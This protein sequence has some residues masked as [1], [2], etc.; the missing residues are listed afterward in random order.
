MPFQSLLGLWPVSAME[1]FAQ[2]G[3]LSNTLMHLAKTTKFQEWWSKTFLTQDQISIQVCE[4]SITSISKISATIK[5]KIARDNEMMGWG[6]MIQ[7]AYHNFIWAW[8]SINFYLN[9]KRLIFSINKVLVY[10]RKYSKWKKLKGWDNLKVFAARQE[11]Q[12]DQI[13]VVH[14][15]SVWWF[16]E[17]SMGHEAT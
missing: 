16:N 6:E 9:F 8:D 2:A 7:S 13:R 3:T 4:H 17:C 5:T 11:T 15:A 12:M 14:C 10:N 1:W